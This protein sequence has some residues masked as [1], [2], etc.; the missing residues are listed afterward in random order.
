MNEFAL[1][2]TTYNKYYGTALNPYDKTRIAGGSSGGT[3]GLVGSGAL[4]AGLGTDHSGSI[5]VPAS[6]NGCVGYKP[7]VNRWPSDFG[8][9]A[10]HIKDTAGP[11]A[12][13][14][15]DILLMDEMVTE[16]KEKNRMDLKSITIGVPRIHFYE[17][18]DSKVKEVAE[19]S[20][21]LLTDA[22]VKVVTN[23]GPDVTY[24]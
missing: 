1:G 12:S 10:S 19:H 15:D 6:F 21:K 22:G 3:G 11:L 7:T 20:I 5:R 17:N 18:L 2:A 14:M 23:D 13:N 4:P 24:D 9:K 8:I 16:T